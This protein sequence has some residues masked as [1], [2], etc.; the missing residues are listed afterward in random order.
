VLYRGK[1]NPGLGRNFEAMD[2]LEWL[3]RMSDHIPDPGKHRVHFVGHYANRPAERGGRARSQ[4]QSQ[5]RPRRRSGA[6][7][8]GRG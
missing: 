3:A 7:R 2:P 6:R 8:A 4:A 5:S 1:M